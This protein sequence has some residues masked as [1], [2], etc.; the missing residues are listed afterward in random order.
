MTH[1][2][3]PPLRFAMVGTRGVPAQ[4]GGF[5]TAVEEVG[6]RLVERGHR[7]DVYCR[8]PGQSL[9][10]HRGMRL[11]NLPAVRRR[12]L[13]TL[14]H[15]GLSIAH[16]A[17]HRP[18]AMVVFNAAN[19]PFLPLLRARGVPVATHVDGLEWQR[20]KWGG[21][22]RRYYRLAESL[23]VRWS[24][25][26][27]ADSLGIQ[28]YYRDEFGARTEL[29]SYGAPE[30]PEFKRQSADF[31]KACKAGGLN[32]TEIVVPGAHH[33]AMSREFAN[34][35]SELHQAMMKMIGV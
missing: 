27:I 17:W 12:S 26:L 13:E 16:A 19:A 29:I 7:V 31:A 14:S 6:A 8:N 32:V 35:D 1:V 20:S 5:E 34:A 30:L 21:A 2:P 25:A 18:D 23:A 24:D 11:V 33:F 15:S 3:H 4:Y 22:G 9:T 10:E 28:D